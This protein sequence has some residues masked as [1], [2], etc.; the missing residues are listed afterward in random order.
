MLLCCLY[1]EF[2]YVWCHYFKW[3]MI[4]I[5]HWL[6]IYTSMKH[7]LFLLK[8]LWAC[9]KLFRHPVWHYNKSI[10]ASLL[11]KMLSIINP[12]LACLVL[13]L[14]VVNNFYLITSFSFN[15]I[16]VIIVCISF[17]SSVINLIWIQKHCFTIQ[18]LIKW[19]FI[20]KIMK[21]PA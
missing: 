11:I 9:A 17:G 4:T 21:G 2:Q 16:V 19:N 14:S 1:S 18:S 3:Y 7:S 13:L 10:Y 6:S 20:Q 5:I 8:T 12:S 15:Y